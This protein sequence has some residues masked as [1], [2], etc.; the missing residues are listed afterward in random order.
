MFL[1]MS[2]TMSMSM[3]MP[4][5][6]HPKMAIINSSFLF[7]FFLINIFHFNHIMSMIDI[8]LTFLTEI[9]GRTLSTFISNSINCFT[10]TSITFYVMCY[11]LVFYWLLLLGLEGILD[12]FYYTRQHVLD[13]LVNELGYF[14]LHFL[15]PF[16]MTS[17]FMFHP[18]LLVFLTNTLFLLNLFSYLI[19]LKLLFLKII[20][21][22]IYLIYHIF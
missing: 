15:F 18:S 9:K 2:I 12:A 4:M 19:F 11:L 13:S 3:S 21:F 7:F 10:S 20:I 5:S 17:T 22:I 16:T 1:T 6:F 8:H 14:L